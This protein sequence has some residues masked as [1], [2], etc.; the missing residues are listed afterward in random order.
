MARAT[1]TGHPLREKAVSGLWAVS[2]RLQ[3]LCPLRP[4]EE[5]PVT[6]ARPIADFTISPTQPSTSDAIQLVDCS[7]D[8]GQIGIAWRA[9]DF[10]DGV[11]SVGAAPVHRYSE[12]GDHEVTLTLATFD[13]RVSHCSRTVTVAEC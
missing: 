5:V 8:P 2:D 1:V 4:S 3:E 12:A 9:W 7:R 13:G 11:T 10:G 6:I